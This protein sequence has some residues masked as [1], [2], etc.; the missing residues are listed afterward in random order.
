MRSVPRP[1]RAS[2][3]TG[4][5]VPS[6]MRGL[7]AC[8]AVRLL[9]AVPPPNI[10]AS[11]SPTLAPTMR[12]SSQISMTTAAARPTRERDIRNRHGRATRPSPRACASPGRRR[13]HRRWPPPRRPLPRRR[14]RRRR[15]RR[16]CGRASGS[17]QSCPCRNRAGLPP[18]SSNEAASAALLPE[19]PEAGPVRHCPEH[20]PTVEGA[21]H[22]ELHRGQ[23]STPNVAGR[24]PPGSPVRP[25]RPA[26]SRR[27]PACPALSLAPL[28]SAA[29]ATSSGRTRSTASA[30]RA[31]SM[32][33]HRPSVATRSIPRPS[34][35]SNPAGLAAPSPRRGLRACRDVRL[36]DAAS[37]PNIHASQS[38]ALARR[39]G[40]RPRFR[41]R[42]RRRNQLASGTSAIDVRE[43]PGPV[44]GH[45]PCLVGGGGTADGLRR[46]GPSRDA[47]S[48]V[49]DDEEGAAGHPDRATLSSPRPWSGLPPSSSNGAA[50]AA[51]LPG[52][53][54]PVRRCPAHAPAVEGAEHLEL[55]RG[56]H[57][58]A[59]R[60]RPELVGH[61]ERAGMLVD[62]C[63]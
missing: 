27:R 11:Q 2:N 14:R 48:A 52:V 50:S 56:Q 54:R 17:R 3:A 58:H 33:F 5:A 18:S 39:C 30:I 37:P 21:E 13:R 42:R 23:T 60:G 29:Q 57:E 15:R 1:R 44:R 32:H 63:F 24:D 26:R 45:A 47:A 43:P 53:W 12:P 62:V 61:H 59:E 19:G 20:A 8:R 4:R 22:L 55:H 49:G 35:A 38:P 41:R 36:L 40:H 28:T 25:A 10:Q 7:R 9:D 6:P 46:V 16:G 51:L 31:R 34:C